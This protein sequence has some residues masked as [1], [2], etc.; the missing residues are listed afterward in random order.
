MWDRREALHQSRLAD[1]ATIFSPTL[2][3]ALDHLHHLG[4]GDVQAYG[5]LARN[6][7]TQA[8][9]MAADDLFWLSG[10]LSLLMIPVI[11]LARRSFSQ[12]RPVAAD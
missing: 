1:T 4:L 5:V 7:T 8:Y 9:A 10:W 2:Q 12:G 3:Q 11:W 6:M